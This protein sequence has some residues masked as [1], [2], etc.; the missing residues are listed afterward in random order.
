MSSILTV[1]TMIKEKACFR[2]KT[3][4]FLCA[5]AVEAARR[6]RVD[7]TV[8]GKIRTI[9]LPPKLCRKLLK[10]AKNPKTA[11]GEVFL[12]KSGKSLSRR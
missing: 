8:K 9:L 11:Y 10:Y 3:S 4:L 6:G 5:F 2:E 7:I 12:T 1:S